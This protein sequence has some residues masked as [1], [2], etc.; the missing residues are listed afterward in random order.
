[1]Q[2][3]NEL[4][5]VKEITNQDNFLSLDKAFRSFDGEYG[6]EL[7][8][9][10]YSY[11]IEKNGN[12]EVYLTGSITPPED[13]RPYI[14]VYLIKW[15]QDYFKVYC[16]ELHTIS[17]NK[18]VYWLVFKIQSLEP[19]NN[20]V[21]IQRCDKDLFFKFQRIILAIKPIYWKDSDT[22]HFQWI[23]KRLE[24]NPVNLI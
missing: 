7:A 11:F 12:I 1:M 21:E 23:N 9:P 5:F 18:D 4:V 6:W 10:P 22:F 19:N 13:R 2:N 20:L 14:Y 8:K 3:F 17:G 16:H 24:E 15:Q